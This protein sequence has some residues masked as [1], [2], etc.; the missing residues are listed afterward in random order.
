MT[1]LRQRLWRHK[2]PAV[3]ALVLAAT[4]VGLAA[5]NFGEQTAGGS[6]EVDN[7]VVVALIDVN[8]DR[9]SV[10]GSL[11]LF[12]ADQ[13]PA[14]NPAPRLEIR[15]E[16]VDSIVINAKTLATAGLA[17]SVR[18]FNLYLQSE[19]SS[20][21]FLQ[22]LTYDPA[23]KTFTRGD[24]LPIKALN[25]TVSPLTRTESVIQ[26]GGDTTGMNRIIIPG[27]PFQAVLVDSV[28]VF[29]AIPPGVFPIHMLTPQGYEY[30]L[31]ENMNTQEPRYHRVNADTT[32]ISRHQAPTV[33]GFTANAG[34]DRSVFS[35]AEATLSGEIAGV[36][37]DDRRLAILWRQLTPANPATGFAFIERP[38]KLTTKVF[39]PR[40]G[41]YTFEIT[42]VLGN[43]QT[44]DTV[45]IGVQ[46]S[47]ENPVF[48]EPG[49]AD[50]LRWYDFF[51]VIWQGY[52]HETLNLEF[53]RDSG[54]TW[55]G[56]PFLSGI[57]SRP[58]F[59]E[60]YWQPMPQ[61]MDLAPDTNCFLR[62]TYL[63]STVTKS[64][65]FVIRYR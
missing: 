19:D 59:N 28:F 11:S 25:L 12:L 48:I 23:T 55:V 5:C 56:H 4:A 1:P 14:L 42:A 53:S 17:D 43:Q 7:P 35:G 31:P 46:S 16:N 27:S 6:S 41:A 29:E 54:A 13:S 47:P 8:G 30:P 33:N 36:R 18:S 15:L 44:T 2:A 50:T 21:S 51:K 26:G 10:T 45:T 22:N 40:T 9:L 58:G 49:L 65:R 32:P 24:S 60:R 61:T 38:T 64:Q 57:Q 20:G 63:D 52:R 62:L 37:S 39:F 3:L 34:V